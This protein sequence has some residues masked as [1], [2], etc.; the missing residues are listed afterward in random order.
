MPLVTSITKKLFA[1]FYQRCRLQKTLNHFIIE[2]V[3]ERGHQLT[4]ILLGV[5]DQEHKRLKDGCKKGAVDKR[6]NDQPKN[7]RDEISR[8]HF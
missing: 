8:D 7:G 2:N 5:A 1:Y 4:S 3:F 6:Q